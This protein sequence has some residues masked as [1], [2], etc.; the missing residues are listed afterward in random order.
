MAFADAGYG[1]K[2]IEGTL[3]IEI[4][5]AD[6]VVC[7]DLLGYSSGWKRALATVGTAIQAI[8]VAGAD[9]LNGQRITA[10]FGDVH[11]KGRL[12]GMT[13][14][15]PVYGAEAAA[16]GDYTQTKPTTT[17]DCNTKLGIAVAADEFILRMN[18][19]ALTV[20]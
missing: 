11:I 18:C 8:A 20:A 15:S 12:S 16:N 1:A 10:Y 3:P 4:T 6:D 9:G 5:L 17:G 13:I 7:G 14:G 19:D 2:I